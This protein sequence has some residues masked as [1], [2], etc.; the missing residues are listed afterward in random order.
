LQAVALL[1]AAA[2]AP[3]AVRAVASRA[4]DMLQAVLRNP[5]LTPSALDAL[6][7]AVELTTPLLIAT[8]CAVGLVGIVQTRALLAPKR[9]APDLT[10]LSPASLLRS[11]FSAQRGFAILRALLTAV[12][13]GYLVVTRLAEHMAD[14]AHATGNLDRAAHVTA[15]LAGSV[16]R[17]TALVVFALAVADLLVTRRSWLARLRM[18]KQEVQREH[19][20]AEGDPQ[21]KAARTRAHQEMLAS[22][23]IAAVRNATVVIIN[24]TR[25]ANALRYVD[26]EDEAPVLVAK[27]EG[28]LARRIV[29]AAHAWGVPVVQDVPVAQALAALSEGDAIPA[30]LY[31][32]VAIILKE[33]ASEPEA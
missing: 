24:P 28:E 25:L 33:L 10:R 27:A 8:A 9:V 13:A 16:V 21:L 5:E 18:S 19:R 26:G 3:A 31:E 17:D 14:L 15:S 6:R 7:E 12:V 11:V 2:L 32:A 20:E 22:A 30:A 23:T 29:E 1:V 4:R